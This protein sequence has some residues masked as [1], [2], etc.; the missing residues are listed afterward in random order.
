MNTRFE[1]R[2]AG[3]LLHPTSLPGGRLDSDA[4]SLLE[5]MHQHHLSTWQILPLSL[6]DPTGSPY[7]SRSAF[8]MDPALLDGS[9]HHEPVTD[10]QLGD[11]RSRQADWIEDFA[12][13]EVIRQQ[14]DQVPWQDW[15]VPLRDRESSALQTFA[16]HH[17]QEIDRVLRDQYRIDRRWQ[18][19]RREAAE[20]GILLFGDLPIFVALDSADVWAHRDQFLLDDQGQPRFVAGV[21]PD[22]FSATGQRWGNPHYDWEQMQQDGFA[23]WTSRL[24]RQFECFD[25]VR[26]DH[27]RGLVASWMI[28]AE[29]ETAVDGYWQPVPGEAL[30]DHL[31]QTFG[32]LPVVAED[33]GIITPEV[34]ALRRRFE[35]PGMAVLQFGF[36]HFDDN[37][38]KPQNITPDRVVYTGTHDNDTTLGWFQSLDPGMQQNVRQQLG[39]GAGD[40]VVMAMIDRA[41]ASRGN[42]AIFPLQDLLALGSEARMNIPG[43]DNG[44]WNWR[45]N[46]S[47]LEDAIDRTR[48]V[49]EHI[50]QTG[51][52]NED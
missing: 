11:F 8:A 42:L 37:P 13:F 32:P 29:S 52:C 6:P 18:T 21:P 41:L 1:R 22:Y 31:Q 15:P 49:S 25:L 4:E 39:I 35:L 9:L 20:R 7:Q 27:F 10:Q 48:L 28:P 34:E 3:L 24:K 36:D 12:C 14:Q 5:W 26:I 19:I 16:D 30:L 38:H 2:R 51:R 40:D 43:V 50:C 17:R 47:Q 23:W 44:N 46:W 33:L 45:F